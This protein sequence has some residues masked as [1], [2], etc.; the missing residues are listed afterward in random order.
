MH[1]RRVIQATIALSFGRIRKR[2]SASHQGRFGSANRGEIGFHSVLLDLL[3]QPRAKLTDLRLIGDRQPLETRWSPWAFL[4]GLAFLPS[5]RPSALRGCSTRLR[6]ASST[7]ETERSQRLSLH[8]WLGGQRGRQITT[9][10]AW[11]VRLEVSAALMRTAAAGCPS[12][13]IDVYWT[14]VGH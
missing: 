3:D 13:S 9:A 5:S 2:L 8:H 12:L 14:V 4:T 1:R 11:F 6:P 10:R 7:T